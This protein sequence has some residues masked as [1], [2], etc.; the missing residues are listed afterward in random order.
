MCQESVTETE[1]LARDEFFCRNDYCQKMNVSLDQDL[2][3][4]LQ[5]PIFLFCFKAVEYQSIQLKF[6]RIINAARC[7]QSQLAL[8]RTWAFPAHMVGSTDFTNRKKL[9]EQLDSLLMVIWWIVQLFKL[10]S[11]L[12]SQN[13]SCLIWNCDHQC[14]HST[15]CLWVY[16][17]S[18]RSQ[19]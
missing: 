18:S 1:N 10:I 9:L 5:F 3:L 16:S 7:T 6:T 2:Y 15:S 14:F 12:L 8:R 17:V 11:A 13:T 19:T 4:S